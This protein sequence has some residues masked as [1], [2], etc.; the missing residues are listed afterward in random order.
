VS[1]KQ[2]T[3]I[4]V[5]LFLIVLGICIFNQIKSTFNEV[6]QANLEQAAEHPDHPVGD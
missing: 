6:Q 3:S 5:W 2:K 4:W 1:K